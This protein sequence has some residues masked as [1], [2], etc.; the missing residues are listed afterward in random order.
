MKKELFYAQL[1]HNFAW[2]PINFLNEPPA[3]IFNWNHKKCQ[4]L[5]V[6]IFA[7]SVPPLFP[8]LANCRVHWPREPGIL[9]NKKLVWG[10]GGQ[11]ED[12]TVSSLV[13][14]NSLQCL[15]YCLCTQL[16]PYQL[17][18]H[19]SFGFWTKIMCWQ[20]YN[21]QFIFTSTLDSRACLLS[22]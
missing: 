21:A 13:R 8:F 10:A 7:S 3:W 17:N 5:P 18:T 6:L 1:V 4:W 14:G 22:I 12:R 11:S 2:N 15:M 9:A 16:H 20:K 19:A